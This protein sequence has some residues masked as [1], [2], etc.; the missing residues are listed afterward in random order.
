MEEK[1]SFLIPSFL[2]DAPS[3][4]NKV[5]AV[6]VTIPSLILTE[7]FLTEKLTKFK[8]NTCVVFFEAILQVF[9]LL[10]LVKL[11]IETHIVFG[12]LF[13]LVLCKL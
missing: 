11:M 9:S 5:D 6:S 1:K 10:K 7:W 13:Q 4:R 3:L 12:R 8:K 2:P